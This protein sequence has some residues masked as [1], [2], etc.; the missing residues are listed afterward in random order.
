MDPT[1]IY[2]DVGKTDE[3]L[4]SH[5]KENMIP[6]PKKNLQKFKLLPIIPN[7][8]VKSSDNS[9]DHDKSI[10][11]LMNPYPFI[12]RESYN[13]ASIDYHF[14]ILEYNSGILSPQLLRFQNFVIC[15]AKDI[16]SFE[17]IQYR[18]E[19]TFMYNLGPSLD[20]EDLR[21]SFIIEDRILNIFNND[22]KDFNY[23]INRIKKIDSNG[24][25]TFI[26]ES[27]NS[28][29]ELIYQLMIMLNVLKNGGDAI[30]KL[31]SIRINL[32]TDLLKM[33]SNCFNEVYLFKTFVSDINSDELY[34][35]GV[36]YNALNS[37]EVIKLIKLIMK[38]IKY[39]DNFFELF[40][41]KDPEVV[42]YIKRIMDL[43]NKERDL[44]PS[45]YV[46]GKAKIYLNII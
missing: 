8:T 39:D 6:M 5:I 17:Y 24:V 13:L 38:K 27:Y 21:D 15:G 25:D 43:I 4:S 45:I 32:T 10:F 31:K 44:E 33:L 18:N 46:P 11:S 1:R 9:E 19:L 3:L 2:C 16:S 35:I 30:I 40:S 23:Y 7:Y 22:Y 28:D 26:S 12:L 34:I 37:I 20:K 42:N 36:N 41:E 29:G 14:N